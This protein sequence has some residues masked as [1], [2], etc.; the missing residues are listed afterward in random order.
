M[1]VSNSP[2]ILVHQ[3]NSIE[4]LQSSGWPMKL[5]DEVLELIDTAMITLQLGN[6]MSNAAA[7]YMPYATL[8]YP[9]SARN[10]LAGLF[11]D[12][13][14]VYLYMLRTQRSDWSGP[15]ELA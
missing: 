12:L 13:P 11:A 3:H 1:P 9:E 5:T 4:P 7:I 6:S 14:T 8:H 15:K 10:Y 2:D